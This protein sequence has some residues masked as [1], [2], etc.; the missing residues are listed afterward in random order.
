VTATSTN[1]NIG[2]YGWNLQIIGSATGV[3]V[4]RRA[5]QADA[6]GIVRVQGGTAGG[7][8][9]MYLGS[10]NSA[11]GLFDATGWAECT[12]RAR[13]DTTVAVGSRVIGVHDTVNASLLSG[14]AAVFFLANSGGGSSPN[15][16]TLTSHLSAG[17]IP[18]DTGIPADAN[19]HEFR[20]VR[21]S[22]TQID[23]YIDGA[24]VTSHV[25]P[26]SGIP[27]GPLVPVASGEPT[28]LFVDCDQ[29]DFVPV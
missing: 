17:N 29:F 14:E 9:V 20:I 18:Q 28:S 4:N 1:A 19:F 26:T 8:A 7:T 27:T 5:G 2:E 22:A 15:Y 11:V 25:D 10:N 6:T 16:R 3:S 13:F 24:L 23:F 21:V 12:F